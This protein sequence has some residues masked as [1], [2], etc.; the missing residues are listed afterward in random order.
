MSEDGVT[1]VEVD[2]NTLSP[3]AREDLSFICG[4]GLKA[5]TDFTCKQCGKNLN[6][7]CQDEW[8][9]YV[10]QAKAFCKRYS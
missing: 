5:F 6:S 8:C 10:Q 9:Q 4:E 7:S 2:N 1:K 3:R